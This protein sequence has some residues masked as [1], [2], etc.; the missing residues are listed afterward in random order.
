MGMPQWVTIAES[1][2][3]TGRSENT[4]RR[5]IYD[6]QKTNKDLYARVVK[7]SSTGAYQI[8]IGFLYSKYQ[9]LSTNDNPMSSSNEQPKGNHSPTHDPTHELGPII[10]AKDETITVLKSQLEK[11]AID[12]KE[13]LNRRDEHMKM[14]FERMRENNMIIQGLAL[15]APQKEEALEPLG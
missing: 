15:P 13:Q 3:L 12:F 9:A 7:K 14:M 11:Q 4:I 8:E 1:I 2:K 6:L 5:L 10:K